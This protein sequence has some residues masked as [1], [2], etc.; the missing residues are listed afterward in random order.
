[1]WGAPE[2]A[3]VKFPSDL[4]EYRP[5]TDVIVVGHARAPG[6]SQTRSLQVAIE[7]ANRKLRLQ[8]S[9]PRSFRRTLFGATP[10]RPMPFSAV[11]LAWSHSWG[12]ADF[13][14][15]RPLE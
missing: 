4:C 9:G 5:G 15:K 14:R 1:M 2:I 12:G 11:P 7:V 10:S 8:V 3:D 6:E 13:S